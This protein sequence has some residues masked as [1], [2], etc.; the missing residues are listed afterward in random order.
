[1]PGGAAARGVPLPRAG[2]Q[3]DD[4]A[5]GGGHDDRVSPRPGRNREREFRLRAAGVWRLLT[6]RINARVSRARPEPG[7]G[8]R[9]ERIAAAAL[10]NTGG[11]VILAGARDKDAAG[12]D[13][14]AGVPESG[15]DALASDL[16][17]LIPEAMPEI[18]P[19]AMPGGQRLVLV[20]RADAGAVPH[21]VMVSGKVLIRV[22]GHSVPA[23]RRRVPGLATRD[24]AAGTGQARMSAERRPWQPQDIALWPEDDSGKEGRL[25]SGVLRIAGGL[26]LP[27]RVLDRPWPG[28]AAR[29]AALGALSNSPLRSSPRWFLTSR[30]TVEARA[31][32]LRLLAREVPQGTY[33]VQAGSYLHLAGRRLPALAGF[34]RTDGTGFGDA[35]ALEHLYHA[36]LGAMITVA[37]RPGQQ[38]RVPM[39]WTP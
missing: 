25:R 8:N 5:G 2:P 12:E 35:I 15:H 34:R 22:P 4:V 29:Q 18:I 26:E 28:L 37:R 19:V 38:A 31:A 7:R 13:R 33:R 23:G 36:M 27:R 17:A 1:M 16:H 3:V 20:L 9:G 21:P 10:S 30:D 14:I 24:Q 6:E 11:G 39:T 32:D